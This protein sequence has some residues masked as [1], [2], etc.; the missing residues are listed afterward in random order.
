MIV[1]RHP[2]TALPACCA[3]EMAAVLM[4]LPAATRR[5][6]SGEGGD[7]FSQSELHA[8]SC[9][10]CIA[11]SWQWPLCMLQ[12]LTQPSNPAAQ[13]EW[14]LSGWPH[15]FGRL[16]AMLELI[17][18]YTLPCSGGAPA[19][20]ADPEA[21]LPSASQTPRTDPWSLRM[22]DKYGLDTSQFTYDPARGPPT[23]AEST[24]AALV[25]SHEH[26]S[27]RCTIM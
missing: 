3:V 18:A 16:S 17:E 24:D 23:G 12:L 21:G 10:P 4:H 11:L 20:A 6:R 13:R 27:R 19:A 25:E 26:A 5:M 15:C 22:R 9:Q 14:C 7:H 8:N 1:C 2:G